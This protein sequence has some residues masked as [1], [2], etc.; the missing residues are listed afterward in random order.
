LAYRIL[1]KADLSGGYLALH[2]GDAGWE[3][4]EERPI[5]RAR[6]AA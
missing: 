4:I 2:H 1:R 3:I 6:E 5:A